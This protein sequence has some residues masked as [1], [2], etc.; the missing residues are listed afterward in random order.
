MF[1]ALRLMVHKSFGTPSRREGFPNGRSAHA[2]TAFGNIELV[3]LRAAPGRM[4]PVE[5]IHLHAL[6]ARLHGVYPVSMSAA[7]KL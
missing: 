6:A 7:P 4:L 2:M 3:R 5:S 1:N